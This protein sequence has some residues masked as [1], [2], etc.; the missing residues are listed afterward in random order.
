MFRPSAFAW[1]RG[2]V[3]LLE[4]LVG[5]GRAARHHRDADADPDIH[6]MPL[7]HIGAAQEIGDPMRQGFDAGGRDGAGLGNRE[8]IGTQAHHRVARPRDGAQPLGHRAEQRVAERATERVVHRLEPVEVEAKQGQAGLSRGQRREVGVK[9]FAQEKAIAEPGQRIE[10]SFLRCR[11]GG[12][13]A[14]G[15]IQRGD[16]QSVRMVAERHGQRGAILDGETSL[17]RFHRFAA[18]PHEREQRLGTLRNATT[19]KP[20]RTQEREEVGLLAPASRRDLQKISA[21]LAAGENPVLLIEDE[22]RLGK[23][24][25]DPPEG[26]IVPRLPNEP[27]RVHR[28]HHP[29]STPRADG[30]PRPA[31]LHLMLKGAYATGG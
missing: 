25:H 14:M 4:E 12:V 1:R 19:E 29:T 26:S 8:L 6:E 24:L 15:L 30:Q 18:R 9:T 20:A 23:N 22:H 3:G 10:T 5:I 2:E 28:A 17:A 16:D 31:A 7:D 13:G 21:A 11:G 27:H